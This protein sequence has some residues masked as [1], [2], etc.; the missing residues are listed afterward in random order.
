MDRHEKEQVI[1]KYYKLIMSICN[2]FYINDLTQEEKEQTILTHLSEKLDK[3]DKTKAKLSTYIK[4]VCKNKLINMTKSSKN[5]REIPFRNVFINEEDTHTK[6][7]KDVLLLAN[8]I[9]RKHKHKNIIFDIMI[10]VSQAEVARVH[11]VSRQYINK[12]WQE[13]LDEVR[14]KLT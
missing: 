6:E 5:V 7:E 11:N 10:G 3:Y 4:H 8:D 13:F 9:M 14:A 2:R 1:K 12:L